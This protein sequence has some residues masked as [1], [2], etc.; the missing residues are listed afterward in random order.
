M[1]MADSKVIWVFCGED[2]SSPGAVFLDFAG[3]ERWIAD[4]RL[5]GI[6]T[7]YPA[8]VGVYDWAIAKGFFR[9]AKEYQRTPKFIGRFSSA[10]LP[11]HHYENGRRGGNTT[12]VP[13][14]KQTGSDMTAGVGEARVS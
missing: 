11:H 1:N 5:T 13:G 6:L 8:D 3:A 9:P 4:Y 10:S 12:A 2:S 14:S 7:A